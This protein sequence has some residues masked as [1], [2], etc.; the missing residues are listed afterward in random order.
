[1]FNVGLFKPQ[2]LSHR[3]EKKQ[4][5]FLLHWSNL[6]WERDYEYIR[7]W[8]FIFIIIIVIRRY[9]NECDIL[10]E[11]KSLTTLKYQHKK[12]TIVWLN[13]ILSKIYIFRNFQNIKTY[14]LI[15]NLQDHLG[16]FVF[17]YNKVPPQLDYPEN[18]VHV[19]RQSPALFRTK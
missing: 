9:W 7:K 8:N 16:T 14:D 13:Q 3:L 15:N 11:R 1:M 18:S 2:C 10:W 6:W 17:I 4:I 5:N 12:S 19:P